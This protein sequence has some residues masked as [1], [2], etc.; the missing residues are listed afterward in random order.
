MT[1]GT[2]ALGAPLNIWHDHSD[3]M[4]VRDAGWI[5]LFAENNQEAI[6]LHIQAFKIAEKLSCP[7]MVCVDGFILTHAIERVDVPD[8]KEV[9]AFLPPFEPI[10]VLD[11]KEP[12]SIGVV[13]GPDAYTE[14]LYLGHRK[15]IRAL[16]VI[17]DVS[18]EFEAAFKREAGGLIRC[19]RTEDADEV[20]V[21][22]GS[23][24]GSIKDVVDEK[25]AQGQKVG[26]VSICSF[27]PFPTKEIHAALKNAKHIIVVEKALAPGQGGIL[28]THVKMAMECCTSVATLISGLGGRPIFK[29]SLS[30]FIAKMAQKPDGEVHFLDLKTNIVERELERAPWMQKD[31]AKPRKLSGA[32]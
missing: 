19:Y 4:S 5:Q 16:E 13:V 22:M 31:D 9:D 12:V 6:D 11:P 21:A 14:V 10:Q 20:L 15:H 23:L 8:Q 18:K 30:D 26:V 29:K 28:A 7:M 2:R 3:A 1:L 27:R 17:D 32:A 24:V 25:R